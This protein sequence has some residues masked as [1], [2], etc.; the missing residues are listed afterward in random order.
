MQARAFTPPAWDIPARLEAHLHNAVVALMADEGITDM[1][2]AITVELPRRDGRGDFTSAV[3]LNL[4]GGP[5]LEPPR[6]AEKIAARL[7]GN[8]DLQGV[9]IAGAGYLNLTLSSSAWAGMLAGLLAEG[10]DYGRSLRGEGK[11]IHPG[12]L[13]VDSEQP[14]PADYA[15]CTVVGAALANILDFVGF[16]TQRSWRING[17]GTVTIRL[18]QPIRLLLTRGQEIETNMSLPDLDAAIGA[19][20]TRI[21]MLMHRNVSP[22]TLDGPLLSDMSHD[23]PLFNLKYAHA[24]CQ[25]LQRKG[26]LAL[27]AEWNEK[28]WNG[29]A[30]EARDARLILRSL[31]LYPRQI[32]RAA[33]S[34]EPQWLARYLLDLANILHAQYYRALTASHLRFIRDDDRLLSGARLALVR[35]VGTVLKSGLSLLGV[36]APEEIR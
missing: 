14:L 6:L 7:L 20:A 19:D 9:E 30:F 17:E 27:P 2:E 21:G 22:V 13:P 15:R 8:P 5:G 11:H 1:P 26:A 18:G 23:N 28:A 16:R 12:F 32:D 33:R 25:G 36:S 29:Q 4:A 35:G 3:A 31:A 10:G 34:G 24:R